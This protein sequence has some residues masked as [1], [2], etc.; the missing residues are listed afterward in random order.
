[1]KKEKDKKKKE[2]FQ[3][4]VSKLAAVVAQLPEVIKKGKK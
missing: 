4:E 3:S 2:S 1:M